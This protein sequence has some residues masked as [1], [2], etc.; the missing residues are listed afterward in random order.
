MLSKH[1]TVPADIIK[2]CL[3][4][5]TIVEQF[6]PYQ[7]ADSIELSSPV[8]NPGKW[9]VAKCSG[10]NNRWR[11]VLGSV[12]IDSLRYNALVIEWKIRIYT[13]CMLCIGITS[14]LNVDKLDSGYNNTWNW[15]RNIYPNQI[16]DNQYYML[17]LDI[18]NNKYFARASYE[19]W[20]TDKDDIG[21][22][23]HNIIGL[24]VD[25][26]HNSIQWYLNNLRE[27]IV[28]FDNCTF[29]GKYEMG[30][31][32]FKTGHVEIADFQIKRP[33]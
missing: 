29:K 5:L 7:C 32:L 2:I 1:L 17:W 6:N 9:T 19:E 33:R 20:K 30:I 31:C 3:L 11:T 21:F 25:F 23:K 27:A 26:K 16:E 15:E 24:R 28:R 4:Y 12:L 13:P 18:S 14:I 10:D 8:H 22:R